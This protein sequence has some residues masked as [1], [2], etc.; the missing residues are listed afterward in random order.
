MASTRDDN[1]TAAHAALAST[2][3]SIDRLQHE[4]A[5]LRRELLALSGLPLDDAH[6]AFAAA[7]RMPPHDGGDDAIDISAASLATSTSQRPLAARSAASGGA[8]TQDAADAAI[9]ARFEALI[10]YRADMEEQLRAASEIMR[11]HDVL[12]ALSDCELRYEVRPRE[13]I[14]G[15]FIVGERNSDGVLYL[16]HG[17]FCGHRLLSAM[18]VLAAR[19]MFTS[20][21]ARARNLEEV[22]HGLNQ[23]LRRLLP[24][25][26]FLAANLCE[27]A[28]ARGWLRV[29]NAGM[30]AVLLSA[31]DGTITRRFASMACPLGVLGSDEFRVEPQACTFDERATLLS[32][33]DGVTEATDVAERP[34]GSA[35]VAE[36]V[37][38]APGEPYDAVLAGVAGHLGRGELRDDLSIV[39][40]RLRAPGAAA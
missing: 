32:F 18:G 36:I 35:R 26:M 16:L 33:S 17:D 40:L 2:A 12:D 27:I 3:A 25:E 5:A 34:L 29:W 37:A 22:A 31:P 21:A 38:A 28:P 9:L 39:Q 15:D 14:G 7:A 20:V 1:G 11:R 23:R 10:A 8:A 30:P 13:I 19:D 4:V 6:E 24:Q